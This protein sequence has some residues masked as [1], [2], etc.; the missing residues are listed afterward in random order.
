[1]RFSILASTLLFIGAG[2]G[3]CAA[4]CESRELAAPDTGPGMALDALLWSAYWRG[5]TE[6]ALVTGPFTVLERGEQVGFCPNAEAAADCR[7]FSVNRLD[8]IVAAVDMRGEW[9]RFA[10]EANGA[11]ETSLAA[12]GWKEA[13]PRAI[14]QK[15]SVGSGTVEEIVKA[16]QQQGLAKKGQRVIVPF[17]SEFDNRLFILVDS[18]GNKRAEVLSMINRGQNWWAFHPFGYLGSSLPED[19]VARKI[20]ENRMLTITASK[21]KRQLN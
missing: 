19:E 20:R 5:G 10:Q 18:P 13:A 14:R 11:C 21:P 17:L 4:P 9:P 6:L 7:T 3:W 2:L 12:L 1:M 15:S 8:W 16:L